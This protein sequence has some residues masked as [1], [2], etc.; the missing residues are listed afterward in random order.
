MEQPA[1]PNASTAALATLHGEVRNGATGQPL[2]RALVRI[3][4]DADTGALTDGEG[5]FEI[6]GVP[7]GPQA[8]RVAKPGYQDRPY[9]AGAAFA[10]NVVGPAHNVLVA[11]EMP[12]LV[13]TLAPTSSIRG[14]IDLS[15]GDPAQG[16]EL[17]LLKRSVE[18]GRA[19]WK[20]ASAAKTDAE[21]AYRFAGLAEGVY[22]IYTGPAMDSELAATFVDA[23]TAANVA[24]AGYASLFYPSARDLAGAARIQL[25][26]GEQAQANL[27]LTLEPFHTVTAE[28]ILPG[29]GRYGSA[30]PAWSGMN[31]TALVMDAQGHI[32]PYN[33]EYDQATKTVQAILPDGVYSLLVTM[34]I[35]RFTASMAGNNSTSAAMDAEPFTGSVEFSLAGH[36]LSNLRIPMSPARGGPVQT[37]VD[38]SEPQPSGQNGMVMV[39]LSQAGSQSGGWI[40][41][42]MVSAYAT[43]SAPG[44]LETTY[45]LPGSYW[46]HTHVSQKG[47]CE[48][49]FTAGGANLAREPL[50]V[51]PSGAT[52]PLALT[53]RDGCARLTLSLPQSMAAQ[54][55]GEEPFYTVYAVPDFDSTVD[56]EPVTLRSSTGGT[57]TLEDL[58]PG[59]YHVYTFPAP[60]RLEYRN[61]AALAALPNPGQA[62]TLSPGAS[63]SLVLEAPSR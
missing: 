29:G 41:D 44:P 50:A 2:P 47:L 26:A 30:N 34:T 61:P 60:V 1:P 35:S 59:N 24:R 38:R 13:F 27:T 6:P 55:S 43:G 32:L 15:T 51:G 11:L 20:P 22:A 21:G 12:D 25:S 3:E 54:A 58:T 40:N 16:I 5:R 56:V 9:A 53:L 63:S 57:F 45:T 4:G 19:V 33:A 8:I 10:E 52:A 46:V 31:L 7:V 14:Q 18:D 49:S 37:T 17:S 39:I 36:A 62:V 23:G 28:A 48:A 42:G